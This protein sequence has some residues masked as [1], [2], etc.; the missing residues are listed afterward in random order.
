MTVREE[1]ASFSSTLGFN[2]NTAGSLGHNFMKENVRH[3]GFYY[4][5]EAFSVPRNRQGL[6]KR[7]KD[8]MGAVDGCSRGS[9]NHHGDLLGR[10]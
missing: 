9:T 2:E 3:W 5:N 1:V 4:I 6:S 10:S 7:A 8:G